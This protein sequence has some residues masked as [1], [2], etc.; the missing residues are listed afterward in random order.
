MNLWWW[1][2]CVKWSERFRGP[3]CFQ[4]SD[5]WIIQKQLKT[6]L[7]HFFSEFPELEEGASYT[8][9]KTGNLTI[10]SIYKAIGK[11]CCAEDCRIFTSLSSSFFG[12]AK[13]LPSLFVRTNKCNINA[14]KVRLSK[15]VHRIP[16]YCTFCLQAWTMLYGLVPFEQFCKR[17]FCPFTMQLEILLKVTS[18][19]IGS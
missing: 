3:I 16:H 6:S 9:S 7:S 5:W 12:G 13:L 15:N 8:F 11:V 1:F 17:I 4:Q 14:F 18:I 19:H 10:L 2:L